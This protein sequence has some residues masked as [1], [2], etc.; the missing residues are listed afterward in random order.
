MATGQMSL[1][2]TIHTLPNYGLWR[3]LL[4]AVLVHGVN[5]PRGKSIF[6]C[7]PFISTRRRWCFF[8][9]SASALG[10]KLM[11]KVPAC[12]VTF[13]PIKT[14]RLHRLLPGHV[15]HRAII[16][17]SGRLRWYG[18]TENFGNDPSSSCFAWCYLHIIITKIL[19][20]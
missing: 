16:G 2:Q 13:H 6:T 20:D 1:C 3:R 19:N 12:H 17:L 15:V 5:G 8:F 10:M 11:R 18:K 7:T 4:S 9:I 14:R